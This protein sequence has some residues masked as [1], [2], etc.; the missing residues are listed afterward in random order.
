VSRQL[1]LNLRP[2]DEATFAKFHPGANR[3]AVHALVALA[4]MPGGAQ[5]MYLWGARGIG[6]S[7]LLQA[8]CHQAALQRRGC[9]YLPLAQ[10]EA[11]DAGL[12]DGLGAIDTVCIDDLDAVA[13]LAA[14]ERGLFN[15][16]N[17]VR[18][19]GHRLVLASTQNPAHMALMLPDLG[20]R[21]VWG[22][23]FYL[24]A[25][26]DATRLDL[27]KARAAQYGLEL[28]D[29]VGRFLLN[30]Y[31]RDAG[32]LLAALAR[33]NEASLAAKRRLTIPFIKSVL[34]L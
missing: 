14:W 7:H 26:D 1:T 10:F 8:V 15:L 17:A 34:G 5:Q 18:D 27:L 24:R 12:L 20:S 25:L 16:I 11:L 19:A 6:K 13:G 32:S 29:E 21:L 31:Q 22:P 3:A 28:K 9:V 4:G 33:L 2:R 30:N 23:V